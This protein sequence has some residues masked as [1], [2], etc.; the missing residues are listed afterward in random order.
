MS[1]QSN[2]YFVD[3]HTHLDHEYP[4]SIEDYLKH[5]E[6]AGVK[7]FITIGTTPE[8]IEGLQKLVKSKSLQNHTVYFSVG[9]HPHEAKDYSEG[10]EKKL[11]AVQEDKACVAIGEIGL[12]YHYN[13]STQDEQK[14]AL[15]QQLNLALH[16]GKPI[17]IHSRDAESDL[18][19]QLT[20]FAKAFVSKTG[21]EP[22][23]IHCFS[24]T[25]EFAEATL[26]LG[27]YLS[28]SGIL[29]FKNATALRDI[30]KNTPINRVLLETDSPYLAPV[31]YRGKPNQSSYLI[32]TAKVLA[33][34]KNIL[35]PE[36]A[37]ATTA[38]AK[39]LFKVEF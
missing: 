3:T 28:F 21:R 11:L 13:H 18:L 30:A 9:I 33:S 1:D 20:P 19:S 25:K 32:E 15:A 12:D 38:N 31:P 6:D 39:Q 35:L 29:T 14:H 27:F 23:V 4:F 26:A 16:V 8:S 10:V 36:L 37:K 5:A 2:G 17:V 7:G 24:G 34:E 22:G